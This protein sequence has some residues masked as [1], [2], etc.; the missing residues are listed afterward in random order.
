MYENNED[1][2]APAG[3]SRGIRASVHQ[4]ASH[5]WSNSKRNFIEDPDFEKLKASIAR[6]DDL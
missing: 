4:R 2:P 6:P 5:V 1:A 3:V